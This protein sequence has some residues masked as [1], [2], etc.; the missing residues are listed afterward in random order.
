[1]I[2]TV[3][4][5]LAEL[6]KAL[7]G[8]DRAT[9]QDALYDA[10]EYLRTALDNMPAEQGKNARTN[11]FAKSLPM[12]YVDAL[13]ASLDLIASRPEYRQR[14]WEVARRLQRGLIEEGYDIGDTQSPITPVYVPAGSEQIAMGMIKMLREDYGV[15][16]SG[17]TYPVVPR[18]VVMFRMIPT[19]SHSD[20]DVDL[21]VAAFKKMRDRMNLDLSEK[22]SLRNR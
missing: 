2:S 19:A 16:V 15:F 6:K 3:D 20:E 22:P 17:V 5:Y 1:M 18:E 4:Q 7:S 10:E 11:V 9:V 8:S 14:M 13:D 21:T 12:I